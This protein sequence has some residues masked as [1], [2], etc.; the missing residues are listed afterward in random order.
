M[1]TFIDRRGLKARGITYTNQHLLRLEKAGKFPQR[2]RLSAIRVLWLQDEIDGWIAA[3]A[4]ARETPHGL[5][6][7]ERETPHA[8]RAPAR[9]TSGAA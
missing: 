9:D 4:D 5:K 2:V 1:Q 6:I 3:L 8:N 7:A